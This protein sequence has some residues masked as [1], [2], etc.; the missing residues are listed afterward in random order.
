MNTSY[1]NIVILQ[2]ESDTC[3]QYNRGTEYDAEDCNAAFEASN[4]DLN[5]IWVEGEG[6]RDAPPAPEPTEVPP[7]PEPVAPEPVEEA[8]PEPIEAAP[9]PVEEAVPEPPAPEQPAP[10]EPLEP[11]NCEQ[12]LGENDCKLRDDC[13]W[14]W[15]T[16]YAQGADPGPEIYC[17]TKDYMQ[18]KCGNGYEW[19]LEEMFCRSTQPDEIEVAV[20]A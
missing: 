3:N 12:L 14:V 5:C 17:R 4:G 7:A 1:D 20:D 16:Q 19:D 15:G 8:A 11:L 13:A 10:E 2:E 6:C 18:E 9:E